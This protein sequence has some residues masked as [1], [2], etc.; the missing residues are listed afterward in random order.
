LELTTYFVLMRESEL[1]LFRWLRR[2]RSYFV[3]N[4]YRHCNRRLRGCFFYLYLLQ[5]NISCSM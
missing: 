1:D 2:D 4:L 3:T 5:R